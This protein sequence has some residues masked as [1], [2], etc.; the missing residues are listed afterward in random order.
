MSRIAR[1]PQARVK[2]MRR[3]DFISVVGGV[4]AWPLSVHA[5]Q[6]ALPLIGY[7]S[8][9]SPTE[10]ADIVAA[11][12]QGLN[13]AGFVD[14]Q[15]VIIESRFA[16]GDFDRLPAVAADLVRRQVNVLVATGGTV[17][18]V[19]AKPVVPTTIPVIFAMG[20]DPVKLGVVASL[21]R[22]GGNITGISFLINGLAAKAVELLHELVPK[23]AIIGLLI[24][25]K[26]ANAASDTTEAQAAADT[27]GLKSVLAKASTEGEIESAF[28]TFVQQQVTALFV[29]PDS[30]F[31]DQRKR[32]VALAAR[33][34]LPAVS[35]LRVFAESGGLASYGTSITAANR[36]LGDY[37]G[38]VLKGAKPADLPVMQSTGFELIIN[39]KAAQ[40]L[41]LEVPWTLGARADEVI[42]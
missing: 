34:A 30:F 28:T 42:E 36:Q 3:R 8:S 27:F 21:N 32:I 17:S 14:G 11:F 40:V 4:V 33:H 39:L 1:G 35:Q 10:S 41:G 9:R 18:V 37:T 15:N 29:E 7:L 12:R 20:G 6:P 31:M 22:P 19:K 13:E 26:D 38:R 2:P 16:E 24:N 23:A 5:Q 25:P